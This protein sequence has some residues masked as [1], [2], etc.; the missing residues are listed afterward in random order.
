[1]NE[2]TGETWFWPVVIVSVGLPIALLLLHEIHSSLVRRGS[3]YAKP[4]LLLRNWVLPA[5]AAYLLIRQFEHADGNPTWSKITATVFGFFLMLV[6]LSGANAAFF[7]GATAESWR[8]RLPGIFVD[9]GRLILILIGIAILLSWVWGANIGGLITAVGVTSIVIGL[10]VQNAV[11]PVIS[12]LLLLFEQPFRIG[13]WLDTK[14]GKGRVVEVNWRAVHID[15]ENGVQVVPNAALAGDA[16]V[17]LSRTVAPYFKAKATFAF[18]AEDPPGAV[19]AALLSVADG[20]PAKVADV[21]ATVTP[22]GAHTV[23]PGLVNYRLMVP[24]VAPA[25]ADG[26]VS[27]MMQRAWY[28]AQR[29]GLHLDDAKSGTK[30]KGVYL[31]EHIGAITAGLGLDGDAAATILA[32]ARVLPYAAGEIVMAPN[33]IPEDMGFVTD[34]RVQMFVVTED[35]GRLQVGELGVGDYFGGTALTRQRMMTGVVAL[36]D[37][38][39]VAV[40]R[41]A[42]NAIVQKDHRLA[43]RIGDA[44]D[45]RRR[46]AREA[47][48][49]AARGLV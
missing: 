15:T 5:L 40:S 32:D 18:S 6:L 46:A 14:F 20:V 24:V 28:A 34:G 33:S 2:F 25:E 11:G 8:S 13:D 39:V 37:T 16:F 22:L 9:L 31:A 1:M 7:G 10:A 35:G 30:R 19:K 49:E 48:A 38:T 47:I 42:M 21:A 36:T 45:M 4:I 12:G 41:E 26:A 27:L 23:H 3:A 17:N 29:A 43:R 44:I